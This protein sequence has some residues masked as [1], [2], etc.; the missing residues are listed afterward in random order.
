MEYWHS[1]V[2]VY[3]YRLHAPSPLLPDSE[4]VTSVNRESRMRVPQRPL[5]EK[6]LLWPWIHQDLEGY[7]A[8]HSH[9]P[10]PKT[11]YWIPPANYPAAEPDCIPAQAGGAAGVLWM[12]APAHPTHC[13][14]GMEYLMQVDQTVIHQEV[15]LIEVLTDF[16]GKN[17]YEIKNSLEQKIF[18]AVED[19]ACYTW[20]F[21][22]A[23]R[24]FE[25]SW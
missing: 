21:W 3:D 13:P 15:N 8:P 17:K 20:N 24:S 2:H 5:K 14:L 1:V 9:C 10:D 11:S 23:L 7:S 18:L 12:Q 16:Q 19:T 25:Y 4:Q 22:D 6:E